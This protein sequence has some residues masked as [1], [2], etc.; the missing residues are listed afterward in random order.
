MARFDKDPF[1]GTDYASFQN[2]EK[3]TTPN[4]ETYYVVPG[5]PGYVFDP[6]ASNATG[7]K[8]FRQNPASA[9]KQQEQDKANQDKLVAQQQFNSSPAGQILPIAASTG[10][11]IA[12]NEIIRPGVTAVGMTPQGVLMTDGTIKG[13][14][15]L[16]TAAAQGSLQG[17]VA[18]V[19]S[20][21]AMMP[22]GLTGE[23]PGI[24]ITPYLGAAGAGLGALGVYNATQMNDKKKGAMFGGLSGAG[25]GMGLGMAAPLVGMGPL[26][27]GA[28]GGMALGGA[29]L[30]GGLGGVMAHK[31]T[32]QIQADR[33]ANSGA[34][35]E[36]IN[37]MAGGHDYFSGT[38]GEKSRDESMLTADA[39]RV[40]PDNYNNIPD[41]DKW[42]KAQQDE[43]LN[44]MLAKKK[45]SER[46]GGIYYDDDYAK[47]KAEEIRN[48]FA[49]A[50]AQGATGRG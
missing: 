42:T 44:D 20:S 17:S 16:G 6:V 47:Q 26:G 35:P 48:K 18:G 13:A 29:V 49:T 28:L 3:V 24:G 27:W 1:P 11:L 41:W 38:G 33:W 22:T 4:G 5:H 15:T 40:N 34:S 23:V 50:A 30:G 37:A 2:W 45:V 36:I 21:G 14:N 25:M 10:G 32:K 7:R 9:I 43:F 46:K 19:D 31:T 8:V 12:A 39:I